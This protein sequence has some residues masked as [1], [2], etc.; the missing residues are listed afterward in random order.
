M[1]KSKKNG[2]F[3]GSEQNAIALI[4]RKGY[5]V[6]DIQDSGTSHVAGIVTGLDEETFYFFSRQELIKL[7]NQLAD[8]GEI[9][10]DPIE[11]VDEPEATATSADEQ[12]A[13]AEEAATLAVETAPDEAEQVIED[14]L[15]REAFSAEVVFARWQADQDAA[16]ILAQRDLAPIPDRTMEFAFSNMPIAPAAQEPVAKE[17]N[18][19]RHIGEVVQ[20]VVAGV[21]RRNGGSHSDLAQMVEDSM[22]APPTVEEMQAISLL[23]PRCI[24]YICDETAARALGRAQTYA[25]K[26]RIEERRVS[27]ASDGEAETLVLF[28]GQDKRNVIVMR[29]DT[30]GCD[31]RIVKADANGNPIWPKN[32]PWEKLPVAPNQRR[33][34]GAQY[35]NLDMTKHNLALL[36][37]RGVKFVVNGLQPIVDEFRQAEARAFEVGRDVAYA[38]WKMQQAAS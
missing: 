19:M 13:D 20:A 29:P 10:I 12:Q 22:V 33:L 25:E 11:Y 14:S 7:A 9:E 38:E 23:K 37:K 17:G 26:A 1:S 4:L 21:A 5:D 18:A 34:I 35:P 30:S 8:I 15:M 32:V 16:A 3:G 36:L 24:V 28:Q 31:L 2:G 6:A 27:R